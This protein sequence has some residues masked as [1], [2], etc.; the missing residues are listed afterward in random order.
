MIQISLKDK[1]IVWD[2]NKN[3]EIDALENY[4]DFITPESFV[5]NGFNLAKAVQKRVRNGD[6]VTKMVRMLSNRT[7]SAFCMDYDETTELVGFYF[8]PYSVLDLSTIITHM[9]ESELNHLLP[10]SVLTSEVY[11]YTCFETMIKSKSLMDTLRVIR[12]R[13]FEDNRIFFRQLSNF[14]IRPT[15]G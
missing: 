11:G 13:R 9:R 2:L 10:D 14:L 15:A 12:N 8:K 7:R 6:R 5:D 1:M 3:I 4:S